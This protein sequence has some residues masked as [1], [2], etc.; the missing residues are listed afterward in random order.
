MKGVKLDKTSLLKMNNTDFLTKHFIITNEFEEIEMITTSIDDKEVYLEDNPH[1]LIYQPI[2][3]TEVDITTEKL[4]EYI[5]KEIE[6]LEEQLEIEVV[7]R[8]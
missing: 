8:D 5:G 6:E 3:N 7:R 2:E 1:C 4:N